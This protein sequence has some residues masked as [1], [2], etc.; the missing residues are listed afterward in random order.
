[1]KDQ[2]NGNMATI[3]SNASNSEGA[4]FWLLTGVLMGFAFILLMVLKSGRRRAMSEE[5]NNDMDNRV[6]SMSEG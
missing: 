3:L 5:L 1:M 2:I 4:I 6:K